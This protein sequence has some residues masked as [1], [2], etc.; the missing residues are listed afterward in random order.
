MGHEA[1]SCDIEECS[2]GH[3]EW[4][5]Q[6]NV[7]PLLNGN[8]EFQTVDGVSHEI[9]GKWDMLIAFPPCT[10]LTSAG[11]RHYSLRINPTEKVEARIKEREKAVEFFLS[12]ANAD[13]D[14]IAIENPVGYMNTNWRKPNQIIH[15]YYFAD[16]TDDKQN[17]FQKRTCL[18]IKGLPILEN[19][20]NLPKP[21]PMY[22]CQGEKCNGKA[23]GWCEGIKNT[24]GGQKGRAK[25][26][27]KTFPGIARAM[28]EQWA[29]LNT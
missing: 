17:Y 16:S 20:K 12:F 19:K 2:G 27:S 28:A 13:C 3:P 14:K 26:R 6:E 21:E 1:Y 22:I 4:H 29:G 5:I 10:Y 23:I 11:T 9:H 24:T 8:C 7:L 15:P 18:W 25:A